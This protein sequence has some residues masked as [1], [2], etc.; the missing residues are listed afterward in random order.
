M[1]EENVVGNKYKLINLICSEPFGNYYLGEFEHEKYLLLTL[2]KAASKL[3]SKKLSELQAVISKSEKHD[4]LKPQ[5]QS[6]VPVI[7]LC[8]DKNIITL[9]MPYFNG[10]SLREFIHCQAQPLSVNKTVKLLLPLAKDLT[11]A[12]NLGKFHGAINF[13]NLWITRDKKIKLLGFGIFNILFDKID[14]KDTE[15]YKPEIYSCISRDMQ[16]NKTSFSL[17]SDYYALLVI[18]HCLLQGK[19]PETEDYD[20]NT[21]NNI[22]KSAK[23][24]LTLNYYRATYQANKSLEQWFLQLK[25]TVKWPLIESGIAAA[26]ILS[27]AFLQYNQYE[28]EIKASW[29]YGFVKS[30]Y[31]Q[32]FSAAPATPIISNV[33]QPVPQSISSTEIMTQ[34]AVTSGSTTATI[35][36]DQQAAPMISNDTNVTNASVSSNYLL[37]LDKTRKELLALESQRTANKNNA[38]N[39]SF[40]CKDDI[41]FDRIAQNINGPRLLK[42][43]F[44]NKPAWLMQS[45]VSRRDYYSYCFLANDC[46]DRAD[47]TNNKILECLFDNKCNDLSQLW[48]E[49]PMIGLDSK[50]YDKYIL[51]LNQV[52]G[53]SYNLI[54]DQYWVENVQ[55]FKPENQ[56]KFHLDGLNTIKTFD[57]PELVKL[58]NKLALRFMAKLVENKELN[59]EP[60]CQ[61][62]ID[63]EN[64]KKYQGQTLVRLVKQ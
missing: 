35:V 9:V 57:H 21:L 3:A 1:S 17:A 24:L 61:T 18:T 44:N 19:L 63:T 64:L 52:T 51:W 56:C 42:M 29:L 5:Q 27:L 43:N 2:T 33:T 41:C 10:I 53:G 15:F 16:A 58:N 39:N 50:K 48:L 26:F 37:S 8:N 49:A 40:I 31:D 20:F 13:S 28:Q 62:F 34:P 55:K 12:H 6:I 25:A 23:K 32:I 14:L 7:E 59:D 54:A 45:V 30:N 11:V 36:V 4:G 46:S 60:Q 38:N 47:V 22:N